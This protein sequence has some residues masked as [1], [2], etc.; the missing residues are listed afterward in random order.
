[1]SGKGIAWI[2]VLDKGAQLLQKLIQGAC[3]LTDHDPK[4]ADYTSYIMADYAQFL[5]GSGARV[6]PIVDTETDEE[7]LKKLSQL[8]GVL[9]PGGAPGK[10][11]KAKAKF[12]YEQAIQLND[13]GTY[14][15]LFGICMGFE[16]M[17]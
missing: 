8:N 14:F 17:H 1:M 6:V 9:L 2:G 12:V 5:E 3:F 15:P 7:T 4:F 10:S 13:S 11:Y 16:L